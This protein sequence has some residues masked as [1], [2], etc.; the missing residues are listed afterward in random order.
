MLYLIELSVLMALIEV[1]VP[2]P[3][4]ILIYN[5]CNYN[6]D[7][8]N[9][10]RD[11]KWSGYPPPA[12]VNYLAELK[13][14]EYKEKQESRTTKFNFNIFVIHLVTSMIKVLVSSLR[15]FILNVLNRV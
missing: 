7:N 12:P 6:K 14:K 3:I 1:A 4:L 15:S 9:P 8:R 2:F 5:K 10:K 13:N 11:P